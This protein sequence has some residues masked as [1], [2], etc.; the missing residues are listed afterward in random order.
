MDIAFLS[1]LSNAMINAKFLAS[2]GG[3]EVTHCTADRT[4]RVRFP[5]YP[6]RVCWPSD[7]KDV[8]D[9]YGPGAH[10]RVGL[11]RKRTQDAHGVGFLAA[12]L[13]LETGQLYHH[14]VAEISLH[15]TFK[16]TT[17]QPTN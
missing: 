17:N 14:C 15:V 12:C 4:I 16:T 11:A 13:S 9:D 2:L 3:A 7:C 8:K 10:V 1:K 5:T 6:Y